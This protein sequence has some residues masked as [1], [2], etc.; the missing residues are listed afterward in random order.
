MDDGGEAMI[1]WTVFSLFYALNIRARR[2][3]RCILWSWEEF[4]GI[5]AKKY[6]KDH[7]DEVQIMNIVIE[8]DLGVFHPR[9]LQFKGH[10]EVKRVIKLQQLFLSNRTKSWH[11]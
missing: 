6:L 10:A 1:S 7:E 4:D 11:K 9:I 3:V 8:S 5:S 2:T